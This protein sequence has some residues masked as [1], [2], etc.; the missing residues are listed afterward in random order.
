MKKV[1]AVLLLGIGLSLHPVFACD[2]CK[3]YEASPDFA[4]KAAK[5]VHNK[6]SDHSSLRSR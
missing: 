2:N 1:V 3:S 5:V 4:I 6:K